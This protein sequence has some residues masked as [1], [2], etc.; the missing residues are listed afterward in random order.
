MIKLFVNLFVVCRIYLLFYKKYKIKL[1]FDN[2]IYYELLD[3]Q[4]RYI[5]SFIINYKI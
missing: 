1:V 4:L 5:K 2:K 3:L